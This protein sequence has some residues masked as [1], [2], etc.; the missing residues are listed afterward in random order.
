M[1]KCQVCTVC[2]ENNV[3]LFSHGKPGT[4]ARLHARVCQYTTNEKCINRNEDLIGVITAE[5]GYLD[6]TSIFNS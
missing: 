6:V 3:V 1:E 5:D 4:R 2:I